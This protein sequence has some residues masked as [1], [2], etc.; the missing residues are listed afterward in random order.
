MVFPIVIGFILSYLSVILLFIPIILLFYH[1]FHFK[2]KETLECIENFT[3]F[4]KECPKTKILIIILSNL[5]GRIFFGLL[6]FSCYNSFIPFKD[7]GKIASEIQEMKNNGENPQLKDI[8]KRIYLYLMNFLLTILST[9]YLSI[10]LPII[11]NI[12]TCTLVGIYYNQKNNELMKPYLKASL[13]N[14]LGVIAYQPIHNIFI[15]ADDVFKIIVLLNM[16]LTTPFVF[17]LK[18]INK[19]IYYIIKH[20]FKP[21]INHEK[22][23]INR[24]YK[25]Y[26]LIL[27]H[28][29]KLKYVIIIL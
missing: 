4:C 12:S 17:L 7:I 23:L 22:S 21:K 9:I 18:I 1:G 10:F 3:K 20:F 14:Y 11:L 2:L 13:T 25:K 16:I 15:I 19:L 26:K 27:K 5:F 24:F 29:I 28:C 6:I 8:D